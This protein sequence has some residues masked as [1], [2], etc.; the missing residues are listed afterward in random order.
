[1]HSHG[2]DHAQQGVGLMNQPKVDLI[3]MQVI[4]A[5]LTS[6]SDEMGEALVR[7]AYSPNIKERRDCTT[8]VFDAQG[9][10]LAQ[11]EHI[12]V[13]LGSL[14]GIISAIQENYAREEIEDGDTF[15]GNDPHTGGGTHLPDIVLATP[16]FHEGELVAWVTNLAHH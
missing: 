9:N 13:H 16:V 14:M 15:I 1:R 7:S 10:A 5:A 6:V 8:C 11:A 12:P 3:Q 2:S 4:G